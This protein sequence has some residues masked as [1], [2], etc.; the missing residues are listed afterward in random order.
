MGHFH[1]DGS[2]SSMAG[3]YF[4]LVETVTNCCSDESRTTAKALQISCYIVDDVARPEYG[5]DRYC[6]SMQ[7]TS[8]QL[9]NINWLVF[10]TDG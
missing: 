6:V 5:T 2:H 1:L 9:G 7:T 8:S 10:C 3:S 4:R